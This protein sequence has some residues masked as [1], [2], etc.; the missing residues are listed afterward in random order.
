MTPQRIHQFPLFF[1][2]C[3]ALALSSCSSS[4]DSDLTRYINEIKAR[5][6][7]AIEPIPQI[8]LFPHYTYPAV[9]NRRSPFKP[10][11]IAAA[12]DQLAPDKHRRR[13]LLE[14]FP[15][16]AL[17]FVGILKQGTIVWA[18]I[19]QPNGELSRITLG[20]YMGRNFGKVISINDTL[21][22]LEES[23]QVAGKWKTQVTIVN[24]NARD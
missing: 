13:A 8:A 15:L 6:S 24:L 12:I 5:K 9:D 3:L 10:K 4:D 23:V 11:D 16:D 1:I 17:K 18:L 7:L 19:S 2:T 20:G 22:K 14:N 21:L